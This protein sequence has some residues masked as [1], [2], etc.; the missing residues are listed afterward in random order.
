MAETVIGALSVKI[1]ADT[2]GVQDGLKATGDALKLSGEKLRSNANKWGKWA[3]AATVAAAGVATAL[4]KSNLGNIKE[5]KVLSQRADISVSDFQRMAFGAKQYGIEQDKLSDILLD[6]NDRVGDFEISGAG[7]MVDFFEK[8]GP[9]TGVTI[10]DF[11]KLSSKEGLQLYV[12]SLEKANVSQ[13]DMTFFME[14]IASD[15]T[16][17]LPLLK[18]NGKAMSEQAKAAKEL[19]IGLS[20]IDVEKATQAN[21]ALARASGLIDS[22]TQQFAIQMAPIVTGVTDL[23]VDMAKEAGGASSFIKQGLDGVVDVVGVFAD[24]LHG[25]K[26]IFKILEVGAVGFSALVAN[27]FAGIINLQA[28]VVDSFTSGINTIIQAHNEF[29]GTDFGLIPQLENSEFVQSV[30]ETAESMIGLVSQTNDELSALANEELPSEGI[31]TF[32]DTS[33]A[34][35][36]RLAEATAL[37]LNPIGSEGNDDE[38]IQKK[39]VSMEQETVGILEAL[40]IRYASQEELQIAANERER[41]LTADQ[42]ANGEIT[43]IA[44]DEKMQSL[45]QATED[46]KRSIVLNSIQQGF[47]ALASNSKKVQKAMAAA[48][49]V[50]AIIKGKQAAVDAWQAGMSTGGPWAPVVA[51]SYAAASLANTG[52]IIKSINSGSKSQGSIS[53]T[54]F[55]GGASQSSGAASSSDSQQAAPQASRNISINLAGS[56]MF[57]SDS[58]RQLITQINE[59]VGDGVELNLAGG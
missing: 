39:L 33:I 36:D 31:K 46:A 16:Q 35:Y 13:K 38:R 51:A 18:N 2:K 49:T 17:L 43:K 40:G 12:E 26:V 30:N 25:I 56:S 3:A 47:Q 48:A 4:I 50:Q 32:V 37:A 52:S 10:K 34:H 41:Q 23:F 54:G 29:L 44:H 5:L 8:I 45:T 58:V 22:M 11:Q 14:A 7:P 28:N 15:S 27:V 9:L 19:G 42:L 1:T 59:Q 6:F 21:K 20:D 53:K 57:S 24:G 55:S